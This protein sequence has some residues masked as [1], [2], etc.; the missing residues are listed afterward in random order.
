MEGL[1]LINYLSRNQ[2]LGTC[3]D[4][5]TRAH[6]YARTYTGEGWGYCFI[7]SPNIHNTLIELLT[8]GDLSPAAPTSDCSVLIKILPD[9][10]MGCY[11]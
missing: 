1:L 8:D 10:Q 11:D 5:S 4:T 3:F 9:L 6:A 7:Q 2:G